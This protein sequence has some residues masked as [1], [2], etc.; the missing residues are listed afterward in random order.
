M[1]SQCVAEVPS[2]V[3]LRGSKLGA[4]S[5]TGEATGVIGHWAIQF[6]IMELTIA[7]RKACGM[8]TLRE[9]LLD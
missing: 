9:R 1:G 4:A 3:P 5:P 8:A 7:Q 6:W 2:V